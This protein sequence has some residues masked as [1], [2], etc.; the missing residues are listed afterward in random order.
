MKLAGSA[1]YVVETLAVWCLSFTIVIGVLHD[2][3][4]MIAFEEESS[5]PRDETALLTG[6][7]LTCLLR[8]SISDAMDLVVGSW[9]ILESDAGFHRVGYR[10]TACHV[11]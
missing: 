6:R 1:T 8:V 4:T 9:F 11:V 10:L 2:A 3:L 5:F 7:V